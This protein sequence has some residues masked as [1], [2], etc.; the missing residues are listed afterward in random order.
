MLAN[1]RFFYLTLLIVALVAVLSYLLLS[2]P[3]P[4]QLKPESPPT[5]VYDYYSI[6][7]EADGRLLMYVPVVVTVG[8]E[9]LSED[10]NFYRV[11]KIEENRA[12]ARFIGSLELEKFKRQ[13]Q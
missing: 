4:L 11:V 10:N 13:N 6:I 7:D 12:Y 9:V 2:S 8:D 1:R 5:K 3:T